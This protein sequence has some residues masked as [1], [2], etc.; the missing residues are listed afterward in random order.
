MK[1]IVRASFI[2]FFIS[3]FLVLFA[4]NSTPSIHAQNGP[5]SPTPTPTEEERR[6]Q[7]EKRILELQRDIE[8][9]KKAIR[10][11][12]PTPEPK[13]TPPAPTATPLA[14]EATLENVK[15]EPEMVSYNA[16]SVAA[17]RIS[18]EIKSKATH[19]AKVPNG[20][21]LLAQNIA[22]Y[23]A[24]VIKDWRFYKALFPAFEGQIND[25]REQ[26]RSLLCQDP[27]IKIDVD[28]AFLTSKYCTDP[29]RDVM[30][31]VGGFQTA[32]AAGTN[33][34][35]SFIDLTAL[36]RTDTKIQGNAFTVDES[37]FVA[38]LFR[39]LKNDYGADKINLYYPEVFPP[40]VKAPSKA[41]TLIGDLFTYKAEAD[42]VIKKKNAKKETLV[43]DLTDLSTKKS[44]LEEEQALLKKLS[45]R[46]K[47]LEANLRTT[48]DPVVRKRIRTEIAE[49]RK[50]L[51]G[52]LKPDVTLNETLDQA[53]A[54]K[55]KQLEE[56]IK[57]LKEKIAPK[58][59]E[60]KKLDEDVK[61]IT[62]LN[63]RFLAFVAEFVKVDSNG[64]NAL[65]LFVR[66]EDIE[67][68]MESDESYW[69]EIKS[70]SAG[71]NNRVRKNLLRFFTG[72]K[73]DHSGGVIVEYTLYEKS[74]AVV[75]S[76]KLS[77]YQGYIEPKEIS[78]PKKKDLNRTGLVDVVP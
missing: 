43:K 57:N 54:R 20:N 24:Q 13:T 7:E 14:G 30:S 50:E 5:P 64:I 63:E 10:E 32:F 77:I 15:L 16:L 44:K 40:R 34:L 42:R 47:N 29:N 25:L 41:V 1:N 51:S 55:L 76:D 6:L 18:A 31:V 2:G 62:S 56:D 66:S 17:A 8:L 49:L 52:L 73:I 28:P 19:P 38:E 58:E 71:G 65:A 59:N 4:I 23:D 27:S 12:Q 21:P 9:A 22:I 36:F 68:A 69:L 74:G 33:L 46:L 67:N 61:R 48:R 45:E 75:Y 37:A 35:K 78:G 39:A 72:P 60:V 26:Y 70:V 3:G 11:A 53:L